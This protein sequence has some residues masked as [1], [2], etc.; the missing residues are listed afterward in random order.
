MIEL[1]FEQDSNNEKKLVIIGESERAKIWVS[2]LRKSSTRIN[3]GCEHYVLKAFE[4]WCQGRGTNNLALRLK[5]S[6]AAIA[7]EIADN[8][9]A[10]KPDADGRALIECSA[11]LH[12]VFRCNL[13]DCIRPSK[14]QYKDTIVVHIA[15]EGIVSQGAANTFK[16]AKA[17]AAKAFL[18]VINKHAKRE[19]NK[20]EDPF[21]TNF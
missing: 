5:Q 18:R 9:A 16:K 8:L 7:K 3:K 13:K 10:S 2:Q 4:L 14:K 19:Y 6:E 11:L 20:E 17:R 1:K 12:H 21:K 15:V